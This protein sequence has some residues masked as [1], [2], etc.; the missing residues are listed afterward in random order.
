MPHCEEGHRY[1]MKDLAIKY[2]QYAPAPGSPSPPP[3]PLLLLFLPFQTAMFGTIVRR[4]LVAK[5]T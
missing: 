5:K 2:G 3:P 4:A 1:P